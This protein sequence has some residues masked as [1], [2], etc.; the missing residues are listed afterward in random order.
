M[1]LLLFTLV[2]CRKGKQLQHHR[3]QQQEQEKKLRKKKQSNEKKGKQ[4]KFDTNNS[5]VVRLM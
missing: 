3:R 5:T 1:L 2:A 4:L